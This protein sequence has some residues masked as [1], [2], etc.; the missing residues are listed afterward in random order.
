PILDTIIGEMKHRFSRKNCNIMKGVNALSPNSENFLEMHVVKPLAEAYSSDIE[1]LSHELH[2]AQ[3]ILERKVK[4]GM[5]KPSSLLQ[6]TRFLK[7]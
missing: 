2:L 1:D 5:E 3:R 7:P 4:S 6:F